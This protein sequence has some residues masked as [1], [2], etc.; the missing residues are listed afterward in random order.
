MKLQ[1]VSRYES[2]CFKKQ[3][4]LYDLLKKISLI[5]N[6][7]SINIVGSFEEKNLNKLGDLDLVIISKK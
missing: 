1:T 7:L 5:N 6:V 4:N 3:K 2:I